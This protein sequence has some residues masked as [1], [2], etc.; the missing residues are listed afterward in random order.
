MSG[1]A[2]AL[3]D[4]ACLRG[5][6]LLFAGVNLMLGA[7]GSAQ[8]AGP[9]GIG[10]SSLLRIIAGLL[11]PFAGSVDCTGTVALTDELDALDRERTV[12]DAL[13]FW[14][15]VDEVPAERIEAALDDLAIAH[16]RD[17]PVRM[18]S[19]GQRKRAALARTLITGAPIWLLDEPANGLDVASAAQLGALVERHRAEG[20]IVLA[21]SHMP[22][23]WTQDAVIE[24]RAPDPDLGKRET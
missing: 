17:I 19:T 10:K 22:L 16:L 9:N 13:A 7:G 14:A 8:I 12:R 18:L 5:G 3:R 24:L 11:R 6:R 2:L 1:A 23:A 4:L 15:K 20:G 21:A